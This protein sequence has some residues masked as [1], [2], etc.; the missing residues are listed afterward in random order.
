LNHEYTAQE[1]LFLLLEKLRSMNPDLA[2]RAQNAIDAGVDEVVEQE[3]LTERGTGRKTSKRKYRKYRPLNDAESI[4]AILEVLHAHLIV[5][6]KVVNSVLNEF[7][8]VAIGTVKRPSIYEAGAKEEVE[9]IPDTVGKEKS[10]EIELMPESARR[11]HDNAEPFLLR[12]TDEA[13]ISELEN[14]IAAVKKLTQFE[15]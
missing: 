13:K 3:I 9:V 4:N 14:L 8:H 7:S 6:R 11:D 2:E 1:A 10:I 15:D 5:H 12:S